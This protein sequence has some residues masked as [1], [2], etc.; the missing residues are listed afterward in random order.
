MGKD[1]G[2]TH[3][4]EDPSEVPK[5][6]CE[7]SLFFEAKSTPTRV[8][9]GSGDSFEEKEEVCPILCFSGLS[10]PPLYHVMHYCHWLHFPGQVELMGSPTFT[11]QRECH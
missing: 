2:H 4:G 9:R 1:R 5:M 7:L 8:F 11:H 3:S 6:W 10:D